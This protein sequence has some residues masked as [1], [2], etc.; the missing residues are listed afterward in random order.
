MNERIV[1]LEQR[2]AK[3]AEALKADRDG[4]AL[5]GLGSVGKKRDRLDEWPDLDFFAIV[6]EGSKQRFLNDVRWLSSAQEISWI[7]RNTAD[8]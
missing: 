3:I 5:L 1:L 7:F 2:L 4:L 6:R 8:G